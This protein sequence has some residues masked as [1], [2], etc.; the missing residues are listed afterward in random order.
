MIVVDTNVISEVMRGRPSEQVVAWLNA[1]NA[2]LLFVTTVTIGEV[3]YGLNMLPDGRRLDRLRGA[4]ES[5]LLRGFGR[6]VLAYD[7][8]AAR[9]YADILAGRRRLGRPLDIAHAQI[10]A[11]ARARGY[12]V[13]TRNS[14]DFEGVGLDLINPFDA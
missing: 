14:R 12:A 7:E 1:Q 5:Y 2:A 13:A 11:I 6:R 9:A 3:L 10:A 4:F 8:A